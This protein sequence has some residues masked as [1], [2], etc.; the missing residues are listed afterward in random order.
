MFHI[1]S[2]HETFH[3][4]EERQISLKTVALTGRFSNAEYV[5]LLFVQRYLSTSL[6]PNFLTAS[7]VAPTFS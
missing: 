7:N 5:Q 4:M 3:R 6:F 2:L 1:T